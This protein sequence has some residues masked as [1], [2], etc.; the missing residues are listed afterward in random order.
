M[1]LMG[2]KLTQEEQDILAGKQGET[3][4]KVMKTLVLYGEAFGAA[5]FVPVQGK[6]HLVTSFGISMLTPV[7]A[8]M[9]ELIEAGLKAEGSFTAD[10]RPIDYGNVPCSPLEKLL[11]GK[12]I[13]GKQKDYEAQLEKLGLKSEKSFTCTCYLDEVGNQPAYG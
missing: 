12:L 7:F 8:I 4:A 3:L 6:G 10:P 13:Y 11:F 5:E 2:L 9:D 1:I